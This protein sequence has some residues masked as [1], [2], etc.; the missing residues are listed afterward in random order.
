MKLDLIPGTKSNGHCG[1]WTGCCE[2]CF[3]EIV[4]EKNTNEEKFRNYFK[5]QNSSSLVKDFFKAGKNKSDKIKYMIIN[6]LI[7]LMEDIIIR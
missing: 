7:K 4:Y 2:E 5:Y 1:T 6:E 3:N